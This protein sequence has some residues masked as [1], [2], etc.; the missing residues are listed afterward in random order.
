MSSSDSDN[1]EEWEPPTCLCQDVWHTA[2]CKPGTRD[3]ENCQTKVST[4]HWWMQNTYDHY[5]QY[6]GI[7]DRD[8]RND[9]AFEIAME[10]Y[11]LVDE[12]R[13]DFE[14]LL[15]EDFDDK[16]EELKACFPTKP[17]PTCDVCGVVADYL[18][19]QNGDH[20]L[21]H[22]CMVKFDIDEAKFAE[23]IKL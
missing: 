23:M 8:E 22:Q 14:Y 18:P 20:Y 19:I 6:C 7:N 15:D 16:M 2:R 9:V 13:D 1:E 21:C 12:D 17:K 4:T 10:I 5:K 11:G 3:F